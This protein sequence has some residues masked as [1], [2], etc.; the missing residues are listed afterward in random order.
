MVHAFFAVLALGLFVGVDD[1]KD[2]DKKELDHLN[3]EW[4][5]V[6]GGRTESIPLRKR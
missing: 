1:A 6:S 2:E 5:T 3:G 4:E